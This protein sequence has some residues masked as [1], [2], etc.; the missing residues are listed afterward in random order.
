MERNPKIKYWDAMHERSNAR[1]PGAL[2]E[3]MSPPVPLSACSK[4]LATPFSPDSERTRTIEIR[5]KKMGN[6]D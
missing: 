2:P 3:S 5:R 4:T 1:V 6:A